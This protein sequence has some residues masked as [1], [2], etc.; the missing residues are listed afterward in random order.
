[1][2]SRVGGMRWPLN[3]DDF[4]EVSDV[5]S[6]RLDTGVILRS[7]KVDLHESLLLR[8]ISGSH[9]VRH[10]RSA[11]GLMGSQAMQQKAVRRNTDS[12]ETT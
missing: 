1:M 6:G 8:E 7:C 11:C 5:P 3:S 4:E 12:L 2:A 9:L 10:A